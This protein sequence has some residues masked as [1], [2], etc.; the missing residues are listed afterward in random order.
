MFRTELFCVI[1]YLHCRNVF[2]AAL[3]AKLAQGEEGELILDVTKPKKKRHLGGKTP[4]TQTRLILV[5]SFGTMQLFFLHSLWL[6]CG[7]TL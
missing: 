4:S 6:G 7:L 1:S 3:H 5:P 2:H